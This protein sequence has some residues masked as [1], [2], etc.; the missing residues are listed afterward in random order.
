V[1]LISTA[2]AQGKV[3]GKALLSITNSNEG[4][5]FVNQSTG[6]TVNVEQYTSSLFPRFGQKESASTAALYAGLGTPLDQVNLIMGESIFV[7]PTYALLQAFPRTSFKGEFAIPPG[8]HGDDIDYYFGGS[9]NFNNTEFIKAFSQS[10]LAFVISL[11]PNVKFDPTNITPRWNKYS[12]GTTRTEMLFNE[13]E[14]GL[15]LV[16]PTTTD[17]ALLNRCRFWESVSELTAQ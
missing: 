17:P 14:N 1:L 16:Q 13:T 7:C 10:F 3:N 2:L 6:P 8:H 9:V 11:D 15:P 4:Y 12:V 5:I